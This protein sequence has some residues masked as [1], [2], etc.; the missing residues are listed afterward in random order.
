MVLLPSVTQ[1]YTQSANGM[2]HNNIYCI[3]FNV[4][5]LC[6]SFGEGLF[7]L[8]PIFNRMQVA[9]QRSTTRILKI[10]WKHINYRIK[11]LNYC[12]HWS[13][14]IIWFL[15]GCSRVWT[16]RPLEQRGLSESLGLQCGA[17]KQYSLHIFNEHNYNDLKLFVPTVL[18]SGVTT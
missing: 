16:A 14:K 4:S 8:S 6:V 5:V 11:S 7:C 2:P 13:L 10:W 17:Q 1:F 9:A 12:S 15:C 3:T 18:Q